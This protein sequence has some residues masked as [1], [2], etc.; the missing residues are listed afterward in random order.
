M[1]LPLTQNLPGAELPAWEEAGKAEQG[2]HCL[3][4]LGIIPRHWP[5]R[6]SQTGDRDR[7]PVFAW[8]GRQGWD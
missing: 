1:G 6:P 5:D 2:E 7:M 4:R 3:L 8:G